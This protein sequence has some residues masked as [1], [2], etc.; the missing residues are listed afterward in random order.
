MK[1][2]TK[3][4]S[5]VQFLS[6]IGSILQKIAKNESSR[7]KL[8]PIPLPFSQTHLGFPSPP[9]LSFVVTFVRV[10]RPHHN[11]N[12]PPSTT[13]QLEN[14]P[15]LPSSSSPTYNT[16]TS[17]SLPPLGNAAAASRDLATSVRPLSS[18]H[19]PPPPDLLKSSLQILS[20]SPCTTSIFT[21]T[22]P[23]SLPKDCNYR[24]CHSPPSRSQSPVQIKRRRRSPIEFK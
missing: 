18:N 16:P 1:N 10:R 7:L 13:F 9:L 22:S 15:I 19:R 6:L 23:E 2:R 20:R 3:R 4:I 8:T 24:H 12:L 17:I 21:A 11:N 14:T 5:S